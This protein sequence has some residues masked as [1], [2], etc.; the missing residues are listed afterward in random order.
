MKGHKFL[1]V[2]GILM[3]IASALTII[4][5][6]FV[7][8]IGALAAGVGVGSA[9]TLNYY[10]VLILTLAGG[11]CELI[12]GILGVKH[13]KRSCQSKKL[14]GWG[15]VVIVFCILSMIFNL[16][17]SGDF[18]VVSV[19]TGLVVPGLYIYGAVL[20]SKADDTQPAA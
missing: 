15:I 12:A 3:I 6:V 9:L 8:G 19:L 16:V 7:A 13:S 1:K 11:I 17:N 4:A 2:T 20:N 14:V 5:G 10:L 18:D